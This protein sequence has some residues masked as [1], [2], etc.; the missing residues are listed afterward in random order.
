MSMLAG[1]K[2]VELALVPDT[3]LE[4]TKSTGMLAKAAW[5]VWL[6]IASVPMRVPVKRET[7]R[8]SPRKNAMKS[9]HERPI[10]LTVYEYT[11]YPLSRVFRLIRVGLLVH[12]L[13][14]SIECISN[15]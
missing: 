7:A 2:L 5:T 13:C 4:A 15:I 12:F 14:G 6:P 1:V 3:L 9:G 8:V 11:V 10:L